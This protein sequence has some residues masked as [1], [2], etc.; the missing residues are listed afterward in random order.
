MTALLPILF[1]A[2]IIPGRRDTL[3]WG[4]RPLISF[5]YWS[6]AM[7][8]AGRSSMTIMEGHYAISRRD[9]FDRYFEDYAPHWLPTT[10]RNGIGASLALLFVLRRA[11]VL[12]TSFDGFAMRNT[13][14]WRLESRLCRLAGVKT[15]VLP[16]G[17]DVYTYSRVIDISMRYGLLA[18]YPKLAVIEARTGRQV[19]HWVKNAD[20]IVSA[21]MIDGV[22]RWDVTVNNAFTIDTADWA[23]KRDY[24]EADGKNAAVRILH[25]P[26]HR[27]FKGTEFLL[28]AVDALKAEGYKIDLILLEKIPNEQV[29]EIMQ[30]VDILAEQFIAPA[31]AMS[32]IE[33]MAS[34]L[35]VLANLDHEDYTRV[36]R[37][38]GFLDECPILSSPPERLR[39]NLRVLISN[40]TL[41]EELGRA[42]RAFAEKYHSDA[43][44]QYM[45]GAIHDRIL[46]GR[47]VDLINL[48]HPLKS[49]FNRRTPKVSHPLTENRLPADSPYWQ[50]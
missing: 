9:D 3:V 22:G 32:G 5:K 16:F 25:T 43:T 48:F 23:A 37:R 40:P 18:S 24:S 6:R 46:H 47:E 26:N 11:S 41:R 35:P 2:A 27:G 4:S 38:Y 49:D 39:D 8:R 10:I 36:F 14:W 44:A 30:T 15:V 29:R 28:N 33:G 19:A 20:C 50:C 34:G 17:A 1:L 7:Q 13:V 21:F 45:F 12:H 42:G 31:Y